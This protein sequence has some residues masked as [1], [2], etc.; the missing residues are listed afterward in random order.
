[1][2]LRRCQPIQPRSLHSVLRH[3]FAFGVENAEV[4]LRETM[5]LRCGQPIQP[6][7]LDRVLRHAFAVLVEISEVA[8]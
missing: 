5:A 3:A 8:L 1:M 7:S 6:R 4:V 2:A